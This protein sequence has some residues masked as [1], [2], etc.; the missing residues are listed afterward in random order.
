M[1]ELV[2][3][4]L[5][6]E[7]RESL[8]NCKMLTMCS[9]FALFRSCAICAYTVHKN[10]PQIS[11]TGFCYAGNHSISIVEIYKIFRRPDYR[12]IQRN[13]FSIFDSVLYLW[14]PGGSTNPNF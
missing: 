11:M 14:H 5:D 9:K 1:Q 7:V 10:N 4:L 13:L 12:T 2:R 6:C 3:S 8:G